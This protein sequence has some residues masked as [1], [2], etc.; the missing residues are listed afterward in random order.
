MPER[1]CSTTTALHS[2]RDFTRLLQQLLQTEWQD[3]LRPQQ[4][5]ALLLL[6]LQVQKV[7]KGCWASP[8][9]LC[10]HLQRDGHRGHA[11]HRSKK[12][13][14]LRISSPGL[15]CQCSDKAVAPVPLSNSP[16]HLIAK[17]QLRLRSRRGVCRAGAN[18]Q[19]VSIHKVRAQSQG[20][21]I[22]A[23]RQSL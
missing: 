2:T 7:Y 14:L 1:K 19:D 4:L 20:S 18:P 6:Q 9:P 22:H 16:Q 17:M 10:L 21:C 3:L 12:I 11:P 23:L 5:P 8:D 15:S 13:I